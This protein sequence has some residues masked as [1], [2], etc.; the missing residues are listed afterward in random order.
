ML[1]SSKGLYNNA[2]MSFVQTLLGIIPGPIISLSKKV[3]MKAREN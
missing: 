3:L 2:F 1:A